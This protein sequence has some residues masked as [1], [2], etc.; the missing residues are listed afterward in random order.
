M[1]ILDTPWAL[2]L[3]LID[4]V[5]VGLSAWHILLYKRS[6]AS[7]LLWINVVVLLPLV[8]TLIYVVLGVNRHGKRATIKE[9]HN[10]TVR[11]QLSTYSSTLLPP[12]LRGDSPDDTARQ[13]R[14]A[15]SFP[16][17]LDSFASVLSRLGRYAAVGGNHVGFIDGGDALF[18]QAL[19]AIA[20]ARSFV[21]IETYI[22]D[23]DAVGTRFLDAL[24]AA[25]DRGVQCALLFDAVG[26]L[27][28]DQSLLDRCRA[29]GV[30]IHAFDQRSLLRGR[31]QINL[32]NHRKILVVD[33]LAGFTG[34]TNISA[35]HL[36]ETDEGTRSEDVHVRLRGP[37]VAQLTAVFA[38]DWYSTTGEH[39]DQ[40][41]YFPHCGDCGDAVCR[42]LPSGPDGD[43]GA[44]HK[45][46]VA[47]IHSAG[48]TLEIVT[49][50]FI[51]SEAVSLALELAAMRGVEVTIILPERLDHW[52]VGQATNAYLGPLLDAGVGIH[53]RPGA[54]LHAK[55]TVVDGLWGLVG[56]SNVDPRGYW[57]NYELNL[58]IVEPATLATMGAW[59]AAQRERSMPLDAGAWRKRGVVVRAWENFWALFSPLL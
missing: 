53:R 11:Q 49:P 16:D 51:P 56:S 44:F 19:A 25:A 34:G 52:F 43:H 36:A 14:E 23:C 31:F 3:A 17:H 41:L 18:E 12:P 57:L 59:I 47:A 48:R 45:L 35:R 39:L 13:P 7:A 46:L 32:R 15:D 5:A 6:S 54:L 29:R 8:G 33:G 30:R 28:L 27:D 58:G 42:V 20:D 21:L 26:S 55:L 22:F 24:G 1:P 2:P 40:D 9:L 37:A 10:R 38:E 50:Y 4:L